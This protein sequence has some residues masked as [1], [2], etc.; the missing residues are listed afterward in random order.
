MSEPKPLSEDQLARFEQ[1]AAQ[2]DNVDPTGTRELVAEV[3]RL[4]AS[5]VEWQE[6]LHQQIDVTICRFKE[7]EVLAYKLAK[8]VKCLELLGSTDYPEEPKV[9]SW[10]VAEARGCLAALNAEEVAT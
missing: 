3:R 1:L 6:L 7:R 9:W 10:W 4:K 5:E 2:G 8:A